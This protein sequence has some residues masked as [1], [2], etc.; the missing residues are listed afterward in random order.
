M[1]DF[2]THPPSG[3]EEP[4]G[5]QTPASPAPPPPVG[6]EPLTPP[7]PSFGAE[8]TTRGNKKK[9]VVVLVMV[10]LA[11]AGAAAFQVIGGEDE[12]RS[13]TGEFTLTDTESVMGEATSCRGTGGYDD[14]GAG[15]N[16]TVKNG[17]GQIVAS[18]STENIPADYLAEDDLDAKSDDE[19]G[20]DTDEMSDDEKLDL[21]FDYIGCV[22][23]FEVEVPVEDFYSIE[24]GR[25]GDL[26]YSYEDLEEMDWAVALSLG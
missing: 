11:A 23:I 22:V 14:F 7:P 20:S 4:F 21:F 2:P 24:V 5:T 13:I 1:S 8:P 15:M 19:V 3:P 12:K 6:Q 26:S 18:G 25:R 9:I 10:A 17:R 16:V